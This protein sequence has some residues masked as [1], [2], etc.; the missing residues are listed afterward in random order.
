MNNFLKATIG[1]DHVL[2]KDISYNNF[3]LFCEREI[4]GLRLSGFFNKVDVCC[5]YKQ[6]ALLLYYVILNY[7]FR[8]DNNG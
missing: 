6:K 2:L 3:L 7:H 5:G 1:V 8:N 4:I